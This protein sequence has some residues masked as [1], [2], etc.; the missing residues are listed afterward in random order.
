MTTCC[1]VSFGQSEIRN[2]L[3]GSNSKTQKTG[4]RP[5]N[6]WVIGI[7]GFGFVSDFRNDTGQQASACGGVVEI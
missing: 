2:K 4:L 1:P 3:K 7:L 6:V 5:A